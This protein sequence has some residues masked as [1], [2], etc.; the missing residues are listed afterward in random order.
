MLCATPLHLIRMSLCLYIFMSLCLCASVS[1]YSPGLIAHLPSTLHSETYVFYC[2]NRIHP[3]PQALRTDVSSAFAI[4]AGKIFLTHQRAVMAVSSCCTVYRRTCCLFDRCL[5]EMRNFLYITKC[6]S[7]NH[8][9]AL[10][11]FN[12]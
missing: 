6:L 1:S 2:K 8:S 5:L 12:F 9:W 3:L 10:V 11:L 4:H 7:A